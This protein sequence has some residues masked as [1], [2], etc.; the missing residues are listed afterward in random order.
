MINSGNKKLLTFWSQTGSISQ[1]NDVPAEAMKAKMITLTS[2]RGSDGHKQD[3]LLT[4]PQKLH[5]QLC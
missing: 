5:V 3:G 2:H 1:E 4:P